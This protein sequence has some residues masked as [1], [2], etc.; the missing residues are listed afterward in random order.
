MSPTAIGSMPAKGSS[1]SMKVGSPASARAISQRR[2]SPP[3]S[4]IEGALRRR[5]DVE[6]LE[7]RVELA[8]A[9]LAARLDDL[10]HGADVV[11]D[12]EAAEDRGFLRQIADAEAG[13]AIHRQAGDVVAVEADDAAIAPRPAR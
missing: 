4:A 8:L 10:E 9:L 1:S 12:V 6:F 11:L 13:A 5:V 2:R 3:D 7:Q